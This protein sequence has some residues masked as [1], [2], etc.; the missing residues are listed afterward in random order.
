MS[1]VD[2]LIAT[3]PSEPIPV[4]DVCIGVF[5]TAVSSRACGMASTFTGESAHGKQRL[6]DV[7]RLHQKSAQELVSGLHSENPLERSL[8]L[9]AFNSLVSVDESQ[10]VELNA[11]DLLNQ[12][13]VGK[14]IAVVG[15]FPHM[16]RLKGIARSLW[17]L[18]IRPQPG[19]YPAEAAED[20]IPQAD[21]VAISSST[22][23]NHTLEGLLRLCSPR[24]LVMLLGPS[25]PLTPLLFEHGVSHLSGTLIIDEAAAR[26]TI[27]QGAAYPQVQGT[28]RVTLSRSEPGLSFE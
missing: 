28:R 16:D 15:H 22:L 4:R 7:G 20:L 8:G 19:D 3:L 23:I 26:L 13:G 5:W 27:R 1:I 10:L 9:A 11:F 25:T 14:K 18:E 2:D 12:R 21:I 24:A 6:R 17:V